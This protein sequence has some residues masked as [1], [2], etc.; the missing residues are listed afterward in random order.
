MRETTKE[1]KVSETVP[2]KQASISKLKSRGKSS[3]DRGTAQSFH[4]S[5]YVKTLE[6]WPVLRT[7]KVHYTWTT[8]V[9]RNESE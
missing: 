2:E 1:K 7:E 3:L 5:I 6:A 4:T 8:E 9:V